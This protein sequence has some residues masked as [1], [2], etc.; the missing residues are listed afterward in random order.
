MPLPSWK[1]NKR[2]AAL[3]AAVVLCALL[4][5]WRLWLAPPIGDTVVVSHDGVVIARL[6]LNTDAV[7]VVEGAYENV[8][9]VEDG[10]AFIESAT[11]PGQDCVHQG[12]ISKTGSSI[13]CLPN[14]V[15]IRIEGGS[16]DVIIG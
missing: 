16:A 3:C 8:V 10:K 4:L 12:A 11:C 2:D 9:R 14:R 13:V 15:S 1:F 7:Y 6:P 5:G